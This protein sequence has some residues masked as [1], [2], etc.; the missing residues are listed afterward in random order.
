MADGF[1]GGLLGDLPQEDRDR[2]M[3]STFGQMGAL[4][5]AAG[6]KQMPAQRAQY[7]AQLGNVGQNI[8]S[9]VFRAQQARL[10][11]A[12]MQEKM[13]EM[14]ELRTIAQA[15]KDN[16]QMLAT[17]LGQDIET[18]KMAS[19]RSLA[20]AARQ[21]V[22]QTP[23]QREMARVQLET[24]R[25]QLAT[26]RLVT[27]GNEVY[28]YDPQTG[29]LSR[30]TPQRELGVGDQA[31]P[32]GGAPQAGQQQDMYPAATI[33]RDLDYGR[34]FGYSGAKNYLLGKYVEG[35]TFGQTMSTAQ[36][37]KA[38]SEIQTLNNS[39]FSGTIAEVEGKN[40]KS[41]QERIAKL[42]PEPASFFTDPQTAV[43]KYS[44]IRSLIDSD[45][46]D[47]EYIVSDKSPASNAGKVKAAQAWRDLKRNRDN[48]S[49]VIDSLTAG[50]KTEDTSAPSARV[51]QK[52]AVAEGDVI[53]NKQTG[54]RK[55]LRNG[56]WEDM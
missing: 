13:R 30:L 54:A 42:M 52:P 51:Q 15:Q 21:R 28:R 37:G 39:I 33:N 25:N 23:E 17:Q 4:L 31:A 14:E 43:N 16:P 49:V 55:V 20:E 46:K 47:L 56:R 38:I 24:A 7:L 11:G 1:T 36:A 12:Q 9:G 44:S 8:E 27:V 32:Q 22:I 19:P 41:T 29:G 34:A 6:Q 45:M 35:P 53:V 3:A 40:L 10:M 5:L 50:R 48:I 2:L 26:G 18:I